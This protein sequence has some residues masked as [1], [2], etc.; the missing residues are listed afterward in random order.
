MSHLEYIITQQRI[1]TNMIKVQDIS[2][3]ERPT[4]ISESQAVIRMVYY[5]NAFDLDFYI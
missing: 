1:K 2:D 5:Y 3:I 4:I